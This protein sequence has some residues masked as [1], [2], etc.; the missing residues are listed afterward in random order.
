MIHAEVI[1]FA[2][3]LRL[4]SVG[5]VVRVQGMFGIDG[6]GP[7]RK[8]WSKGVMRLQHGKQAVVR[9]PLVEM[10]RMTL[11]CKKTRCS[12]G[13]ATYAV[14]FDRYAGRMREPSDGST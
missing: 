14:H 4:N 5:K 13:R 11:A 12:Y 6:D 1:A 7:I 9:P 10:A 8:Q 2:M 3:R